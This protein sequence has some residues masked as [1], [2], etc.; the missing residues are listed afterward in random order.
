MKT[1]IPGLVKRLPH[2]EE[3]TLNMS[4]NYDDN[5]IPRADCQ[6]LF[7]DVFQLHSKIYLISVVHPKEA[8]RERWLR[9][10]PCQSQTGPVQQVSR[11]YMPLLNYPAF[12]RDWINPM[13]EGEEYFDVP[14]I[15]F[16]L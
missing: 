11:G 14:L 3:L 9:S 2:L 10:S 16:P 8:M 1:H 13:R 12:P 7:K 4:K 5:S 15:D 6:E